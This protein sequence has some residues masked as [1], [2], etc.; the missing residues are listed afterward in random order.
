MELSDREED[1]QSAKRS[2]KQASTH[3]HTHQCT[4]CTF[5]SVTGDTSNKQNRMQT[6]QEEG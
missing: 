4:G 6:Y 1:R 5:D 3:K 2:G